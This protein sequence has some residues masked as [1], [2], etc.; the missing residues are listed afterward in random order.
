M[1]ISKLFLS[2][3]LASPLLI[4]PAYAGTVTVEVRNIEKKGEMHLAI[5][6]DANVFENDNGE[7]GGAGGEQVTA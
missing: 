2:L 7:K 6:D 4:S 5:Y 1:N 3:S